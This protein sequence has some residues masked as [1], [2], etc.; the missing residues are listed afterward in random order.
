VIALWYIAHKVPLGLVKTAIVAAS[1]PFI[2]LGCATQVAVRA[3]LALRVR[4]I[5][6]AQG[7]PLS[8][9]AILATLFT[10]ALYGLMLPGSVG[11]GA[12]TLV[13]YVA[14]GA[15]PAAALASMIVNRL[16]DSTTNV[17]MGLAFWGLA[18]REFAVGG[19]HWPTSVLLVAGLLLFLGVH[20]LLFGRPRALRRIQAWVRHFGLEHRGRTGRGVVRLIDQ[21]ATAG[22]LSTGEAIAVGALSI[23]KGLLAVL[24][25]YAFAAACGIRLS[26]ATI[27]WMQA[28]VAILVLL[29]I[30]LSGLGVREGTLVFLSARYGVPAPVALSWSLLVFAGTLLIAAIGACIE[31]LGF[32]HRRGR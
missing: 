28:V 17:A 24:V 4:I 12:A 3:V 1:V 10:T 19:T 20:L 18:R 14:Q 31:V 27:G 6:A 2:L 13:K 11:A 25:A 16:L 32:L 26:F 7:A 29:P 22:D 8:Y 5:A 30:S 21:C 9:E 23:V 15:T